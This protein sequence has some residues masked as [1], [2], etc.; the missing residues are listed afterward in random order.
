MNSYASFSSYVGL[1]RFAPNPTYWIPAFAGMTD[2]VGMADENGSRLRVKTKNPSRSNHILFLFH[3]CKIRWF[4]P[5]LY[6][7]RHWQTLY[8]RR[9]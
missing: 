8:L 7:A 3:H 2:K 4:H 9:S 6:I 5:S 1:R